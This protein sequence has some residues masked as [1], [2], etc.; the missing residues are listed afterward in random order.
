MY[1]QLITTHNLEICM[2][3]YGMVCIPVLVRYIVCKTSSFQKAYE[4]N[5]TTRGKCYVEK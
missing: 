3:W 5:V 1:T 4:K 2:V